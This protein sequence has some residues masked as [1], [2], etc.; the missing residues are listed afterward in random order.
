[1]DIAKLRVPSACEM[2]DTISPQF[3]LDLISWVAIGARTTESQLHRELASGVSVSCGFKN[4][5]TGSLKIAI[6]AIVATRAPHSFLSV[7]TQGLAAII[8][9]DG[10]ANCHV[11]LR[12]SDSGPNYQTE[13]VQEAKKELIKAALHPVVMID[14][15]HGNSG[16]KCENQC[17][18]V[19]DL[20]NQISNGE[21]AIMGIM[22]ESNIVAGSQKFTPGNDVTKLIYGKSITDE[23]VDFDTTVKL[24]D[25]LAA[26]VKERRRKKITMTTINEN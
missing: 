24:L 1:M 9:T 3:L 21:S 5:T 18:V 7:T 23:C 12:G 17:S 14:C 19:E 22:I 20:C 25:K 2:L 8:E 13:Y 4:G 15:S 6:D 16:K 26:A 11:V 10:N